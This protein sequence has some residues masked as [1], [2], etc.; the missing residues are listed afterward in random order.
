MSDMR[1]YGEIVLGRLRELPAGPELL[2]LAE[3]REDVVELVGGAARDVLIG[4]TPRELDVVVAGDAASFARELAATLGLPGE[5]SSNEQSG[6]VSHERFAT[7]VVWWEGGRVDVATRRMESYPSP[8]ALPEVRP[9]TSEEDLLR[10]D[11][12]V[13]AIAIH[14]GG[15]SRGELSTVPHGLQDLAAS[16]LRVL[17]DR[18]FLDD[19]TRLLRL[20]RYLARLSFEPEEHTAELAADALAHGALA[21]VSGARIGAELR[22]ALKEASPVA[23]LAMIADMGILLVLHPLL[24]FSPLLARRA[25]ALLPADGRGDVLLLGILLMS[26]TLSSADDPQRASLTLLDDLKFPAADRD[27]ALA[28]A[29]AAPGLVGKLQDAHAPSQLRDAV[30]PATL[31]SVALAGALAEREGLDKAVSAAREWLSEVR[32]VRLQITGDDLLAAGVPSGPEVGERLE[33]ALRRRLDGELPE[34][35]EAELGAAVEGL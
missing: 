26:I 16:R 24:R 13:N 5:E 22:L 10:R 15:P 25:L 14:L 31:E 35:R 4:R 12:T 32:H 2:D 6:I 33:L 17:H 18:S 21:T 30:G 7:A 27:R 34:G 23:A 9:G 11:F 19:P 8:G 1:K 28:I 29:L 20:A 3:T